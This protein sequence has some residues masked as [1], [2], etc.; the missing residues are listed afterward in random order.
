MLESLRSSIDKAGGHVFTVTSEAESELPRMRTSSSYTGETIVDPEN[1]LATELKRR[2]I[3]DV[4]IS[5]HKGYPHGMV[6]PAVLIE[7]KTKVWYSWAVVPATVS[8]SLC[9]FRNDY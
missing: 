1:L 6:Q 2:G 4:V 3:I 9:K 8:K 5:G 7:S